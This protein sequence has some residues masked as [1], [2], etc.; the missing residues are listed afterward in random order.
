MLVVEDDSATRE[1]LGLML[2][3]AGLRVTGVDSAAAAL[4]AIEQARPDLLIS[5]IGMPGEDGLALM[6]QIRQ[7]ESSAGHRPIPAVALT[8]FAREDDRREA[9][10]A[11]FQH[12][13][14][15]PIEIE[16]LLATLREIAPGGNGN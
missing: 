9:L 5:D 1:A 10:D 11:G 12:H 7:R 13:I 14:G 2:Q 3:K 8:A 4:R 15:K 6:R 16:N